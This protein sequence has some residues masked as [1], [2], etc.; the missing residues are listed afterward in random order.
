MEVAALGSPSLISRMVSVD[1]RAT[2][3]GD[4]VFLSLLSGFAGSVPADR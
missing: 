4:S 1:V 2:V 3:N